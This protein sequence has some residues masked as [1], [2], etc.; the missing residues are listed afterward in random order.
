[1][2]DK[3]TIYEPD[4]KVYLVIDQLLFGVAEAIKNSLFPQ[5]KKQSLAIKQQKILAHAVCDSH[6]ITKLH[7]EL[8]PPK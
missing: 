4:L 6:Q 3:D 7:I 8:L 2:V 1:M 5:P